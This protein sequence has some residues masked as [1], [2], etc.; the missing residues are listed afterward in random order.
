MSR[1]ISQYTRACKT[2][3]LNKPKHKIVEKLRITD[4]PYGSFDK[5]IIDTM[6]PL[7]TSTN[8]NRYILTIM[9]DL[10]KYLTCIPMADKSANS[11][12]K[13]I[14]E[15]IVLTF[16]SPKQIL[17]DC[18]TEFLNQVIR[19]LCSLLNIE[20]IH[21][22]PYRHQTI[23]TVE[24]NH[25]VINEYFRSYVVNMENWEDYIKYFM[26]CYNSTPHTSFDNKYSPFELIFAKKPNLP[27]TLTSDTISPIYNLDNYISE[28]KYKLQITNKLARNLLEKNKHLTKLR[29]DQTTNP[30]N[31]KINDKILL[32]QEARTKFDPIY[33]GPF[34]ITKINRENIEILDLDSKKTKIVHKNNIV[35][36]IS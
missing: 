10:T 9:C 36:F 29:Y 15:N 35:K 7:Q 11:I 34:I 14:V 13:A 24:R 3:Q 26:F 16:G 28:I 23:G 4:T 12:A 1:Q 17:S 22:T 6:G 25:R 20:Q 2:C 33:K 5:I 8:G 31:L 32:R 30:I 18:G 19:E 21:S 27:Q